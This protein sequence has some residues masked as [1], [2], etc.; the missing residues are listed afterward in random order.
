MYFGSAPGVKFDQKR[1]YPLLQKMVRG[2]YPHH[3]KRFL[4]PAAVFAWGLNE[5]PFGTLETAF[6]HSGVGLSY[7]GVFECRYAIIADGDG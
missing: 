5:H 2:L 4:P 3:T 1:I 7:P 6:S